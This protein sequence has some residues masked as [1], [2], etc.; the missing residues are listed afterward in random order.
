MKRV[1][2][3]ALLALAMAFA[4]LQLH[5]EDGRILVAV[6]VCKWSLADLPILRLRNVER[7]T[8]KNIV[9]PFFPTWDY[10]DEVGRFK[11]FVE[12][13]PAGT[14]EL[15]NHEM[16][17][18]PQPSTT[19]RHS[20]RTEYSHRFTVEPGKVV[21]LGRYCAAT[22]ATGDVDEKMKDLIFN[23]VVRV[24]YMH[25]SANREADVAA[26]RR[27]SGDQS[28]DVVDAR[29]ESPETVSPLLRA[30]FIEPRVLARTSDDRTAPSSP[31]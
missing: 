29:P 1:T 21:D 6:G 2:R 28:L 11:V 20:S 7:G 17:S 25:V 15:Y 24:A 16:T 30:R 27:S 4:P 23:Q 18:K 14:W 12:P 9:G 19:V 26:A 22:Q 3:V 31:R 13:L 5:A 10:N 8:E